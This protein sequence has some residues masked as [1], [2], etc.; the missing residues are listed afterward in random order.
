[1]DPITSPDVANRLE[2][3]EAEVWASA[4]AAASP[5]VAVAL[6]L[7]I[8]RV[9]EGVALVATRFPNLLYNRAFAFAL[10][11][12]LDEAGLDR[13]IA[14][15]P[16]DGPYT[17]QPSPHARPAAIGDWLVA[18]GLESYFDW[19]IWGR[20]VDSPIDTPTDL[21]I[22]R[23]GRGDAAAWAV[24]AGDIF[25]GE[26]GLEPWLEQQVGRPGWTH[27]FALDGDRPVGIASLC[28]AGDVGWL[29][30]GGTL[31]SHRGR[32]AQ[33][34]LIAWRVRDAAAAGCRW[35]RSETADDL[36]DATNPSFRNMAR[37][38]FTLLYRRPSHARIRSAAGAS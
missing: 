5:A 37:A 29:G 36:P 34:A 32:G 26:R 31:S 20:S 1:M 27:Y 30:W 25:T 6:G 11:E 23:A 28:V 10:D 18:R 22:V 38:G 8:E 19:V 15:Y 2:R 21:E 24:L 33:S 14:L 9:A 3:A 7:R 17:I 35:V 12:P 4:V 13:L 16:S